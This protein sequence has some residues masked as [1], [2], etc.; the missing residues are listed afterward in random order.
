MV[1]IIWSEQA[2]QDLNEIFAYISRD[3]SNFATLLVN[4]IHESVSILIDFPNLGRKVPELRDISIRE[5]I[6]K[7]YR[8]IY[9]IKQENI[10]IVTIFHGSKLLRQ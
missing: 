7:N 10:E 1:R 9:Q 8:I 6:F 2:K 5:I 3:S 4:Q